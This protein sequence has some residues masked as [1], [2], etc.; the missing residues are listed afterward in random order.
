M[1]RTGMSKVL[2]MIIYI[3]LNLF[4]T[5]WIKNIV[6]HYKSET[7]QSFFFLIPECSVYNCLVSFVF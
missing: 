3:V 6:I 2:I 1:E 7:K 4:Y 5:Q